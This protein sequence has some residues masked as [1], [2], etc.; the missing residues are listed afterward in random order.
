MN[1]M[2]KHLKLQLTL[3]ENIFIKYGE[4][5]SKIHKNVYKSIR[6]LNNLVEKIK[7]IYIV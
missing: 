4:D 7:D 3:G 5:N 1:V 2:G 6:K